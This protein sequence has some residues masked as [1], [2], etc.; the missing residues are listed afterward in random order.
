MSLSLFVALTVYMFLLFINTI[1]VFNF[2]MILHINSLNFH[3]ILINKIY[4]YSS[5][6]SAQHEV[7]LF[8]APLIV[9][10]IP[11]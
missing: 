6:P 2:H 7:T 8:S 9:G 11:V 3:I 1:A 10:S 5:S 4:L